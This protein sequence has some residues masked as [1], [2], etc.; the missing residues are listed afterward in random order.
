MKF[1]ALISNLFDLQIYNETINDLLKKENNNLDIRENLSKGIYIQNLSEI[2]V[3]NEN[4]ALEYLYFKRFLF[5]KFMKIVILEK[6]YE[7]LVKLH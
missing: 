5:E 4:D 6:I 3:K 7:N 1:I 2:I